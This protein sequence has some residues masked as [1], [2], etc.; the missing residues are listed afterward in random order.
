VPDRSKKY[1]WAHRVALALGDAAEER[2]DGRISGRKEGD[3]VLR[4]RIKSNEIK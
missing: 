3:T 1:P 2:R 4:L